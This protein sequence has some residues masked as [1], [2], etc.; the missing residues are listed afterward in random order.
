MI[1]ATIKTHQEKT[2]SAF[3]GMLKRWR[4]FKKL[5]QLD[6]SLEAGISQR[7]ISFLES[8]RSRPGMEVILQLASALDMTLRDS[9]QLLKSAGYAPAFTERELDDKA[10]VSINNALQMML[11][12]HQ[13]FPALVVDRNWDLYMANQ[14]TNTLLKLIGL[15]DPS[16]FH[17]EKLNIYRLTF[18]E[19]GFRPFIS[20]WQEIAN[21]LLLRLQ[22]EVNGDPDNRF[23]ST[24]FDEVQTLSGCSEYSSTDIAA[25][26]APV[27]SLQLQIGD[28][29]LKLFSMVSSFG[30]AL[31]VTAAELKVETFFP[32]DEQTEQFF[33]TNGL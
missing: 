5:S 26:L 27:L 3:S 29:E 21:P 11:E 2:D 33:K 6:L 32:G 19:K 9:N 8:G 31:D 1:N 14:A 16:V 13:P 22:R 10:M 7:H 20:N 24:L 4:K 15:P 12:H 18:S 17:E 30:T 23:L 28:I 25:T